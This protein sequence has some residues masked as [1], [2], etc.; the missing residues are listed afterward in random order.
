MD[1]FEDMNDEQCESFGA[2]LVD[3][4]A[5]HH[6]LLAAWFKARAACVMYTEAGM[7]PLN[8]EDRLTLA[9]VESRV[10]P[11]VSDEALL[12]MYMEMIRTAVRAA[13]RKTREELYAEGWR[14]PEGSPTE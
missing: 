9:E 2:E 12:P 3:R 14:W 5:G 10:R 8:P 1:I 4:M 13:R 6:A 11:L 7:I